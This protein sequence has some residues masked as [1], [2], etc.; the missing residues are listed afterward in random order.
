M[1][2]CVESGA[3][4]KARHANNTRHHSHEFKRNGRRKEMR[5]GLSPSQQMTIVLQLL[6]SGVNKDTIVK[7]FDGDDSLVQ[8]LITSLAAFGFLKIVGDTWL[9]TEKG[10]SRAKQSR[11]LSRAA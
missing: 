3:S 1:H 11:E 9:I 2:L 5:R 4:N 10:K 6:V 8:L 7:R